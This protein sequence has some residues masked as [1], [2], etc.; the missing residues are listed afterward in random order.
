MQDLPPAQSVKCFACG[1]QMGSKFFGM[2][3]WCAVCGSVKDHEGIWH[4]PRSAWM[5]SLDPKA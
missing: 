3:Y 5:K 4:Q 1:E 2:I